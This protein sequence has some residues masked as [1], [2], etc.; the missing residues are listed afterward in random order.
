MVRRYEYLKLLATK[1]KDELVITNVAGVAKEWDHIRHRDGNL[2]QVYMAGATPLALG[3]ALSLPHRRVISLDGDGSLLMGLAILPVIAKQNPSNL[4]VIVFDNEAYEAAANV[5]TLT[6]GPADLMEMARGAG[7][8]NAITVRELSEF[9]KAIDLAFQATEATVI[10]VK[11][12]S[13]AAP[14]PF[15]AMD[16]IENKYRFI[17]Y[18][19]KTEN[20]QII[21]PA[22]IKVGKDI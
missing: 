19:E 6:A 8:E 22:G 9:E 17:R 5:P 4:V 11:V 12:P 1:I 3:I 2:L 15:Y 21:K 20:I 13:G 18:I 14:I 10:V 16:G 7:I